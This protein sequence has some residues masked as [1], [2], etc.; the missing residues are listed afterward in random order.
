MEPQVIAERVHETYRQQIIAGKNP[1]FV[2]LVTS[3]INVFITEQE[4]PPLC[5]DH[6]KY[7]GKRKP[8]RL[9]ESCWKLYLWQKG[10]V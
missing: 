6:N 2:S 7:T 10:K 1:D 8:T 4:Q 5:E 9:C 3:A